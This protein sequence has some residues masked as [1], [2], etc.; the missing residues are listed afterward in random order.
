M[1]WDQWRERLQREATPVLD[2]IARADPLVDT[3]LWV[4]WRSQMCGDGLVKMDEFRLCDVSLLGAI[5]CDEA[6]TRRY[7]L[8]ATIA[9]VEQLG[10]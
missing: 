10:Y 7:E 8:Y 2:A 9:A 3:L 4:A 6:T 1:L 5:V